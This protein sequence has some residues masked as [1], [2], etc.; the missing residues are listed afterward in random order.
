MLDP[1]VAWRRL[2]KL[3]RITPARA[4][5]NLIKKGRRL[6]ASGKTACYAYA[7][8]AIGQKSEVRIRRSYKTRPVARAKK[9]GR[10][11][12]L[13]QGWAAGLLNG[14]PFF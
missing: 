10:C 9:A 8:S 11:H 6:I 14:F 2:S 13:F 4:T 12:D 5:C 7:A 1:E 3:R